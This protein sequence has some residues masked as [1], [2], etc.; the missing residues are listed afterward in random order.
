MLS[1]ES[2]STL[3]D[4]MDC[5]VHQ[6]PLSMGFSRREYWSGLPFPP[7]GDPPNPGIE[8][9]PPVSCISSPKWQHPIA[10]RPVST[11]QLPRPVCP[12]LDLVLRGFNTCT[13]C[14]NVLQTPF[15]GSLG[16]N[17]HMYIWLGPFIVHLKLSPR[18]S[19]VIPQYR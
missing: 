12:G 15:Y 6:I 8:T 10:Q 17:G 4:P 9:A 18:C 1:C 7:P 14:K 11:A 16:E 13:S 5:I 19:S 2:V 3:C